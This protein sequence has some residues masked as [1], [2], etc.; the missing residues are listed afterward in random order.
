LEE[1]F[2][3]RGAAVVWLETAKGLTHKEGF[4]SLPSSAAEPLPTS[5]ERKALQEHRAKSLLSGDLRDRYLE[6]V[7]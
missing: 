3:D 6:G 5:A 7:L 1:T 4:A 2:L